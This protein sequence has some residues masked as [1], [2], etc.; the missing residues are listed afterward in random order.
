MQD[1]HNNLVHVHYRVAGLLAGAVLFFFVFTAMTGPAFASDSVAKTNG[2]FI[3]NIGTVVPGHMGWS[4]RAKEFLIPMV[5][6][7]SD[8]KLK[9]KIFWGGIKGDDEDILEKLKS[10]EL[11]GGGFS[12]HGSIMACPEF[13]VLSLPF[14]FNNFKEVD[15]I[16]GKMLLSF[17]RFVEKRG[18]RLFLWLDQDFDQLYSTRLEMTKLDHFRRV[19]FICWYGPVEKELFRA[20]GAK[21]TPMRISQITK[22]VNQGKVDAVMGPAMWA[23][24]AQLHPKI[25]YINSC[26]IRYSPVIFIFSMNIMEQISDNFKDRLFQE[27]PKLTAQLVKYSREDSINSIKAIVTYGAKE[28]VFDPDEEAQIK[29]I[30]KTSWDRLAGKLFPQ[31][32]LD[33]VLGHLEK[34]RQGSP[35]N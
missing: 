27:R 14:M 8:G 28:V 26:K 1:R 23:V 13:A 4:K 7:Y 5:N 16:R 29:A 20:L 9:A 31:E 33:E 3:V 24:G 19:Q 25:K 32:L 35:K 10:G 17:D 21:T 15:H 12:G 30:A 22:F 2:Q 6:D 11:Q 34:Y 18:F